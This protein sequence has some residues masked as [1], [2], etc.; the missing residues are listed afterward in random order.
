L[1]ILAVTAASF[2]ESYRGLFIWASDHGLRGTWAAYWPL[3]LDAFI[4]VGEL[5]LF[6]GLADRWHRRDRISAWFVTGVG[7][8][9]SVAANVGHVT[10]HDFATRLTAA[11]PP[12]A[13]A[14][15]LAVGFGVLKRVVA[16]T[17]T[18]RDRASE[19]ASPAD[20]EPRSAGHRKATRTASEQRRLKATRAATKAAAAGEPISA[21]RLAEAHGISRDTAGQILAT[22]K[23]QSEGHLSASMN[24]H[25]PV[26]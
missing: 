18:G 17:D 25:G 11:V 8:A 4:A 3:Q 10:D 21:R 23:A 14:A 26:T 12:L 5:A 19:P 22:V 6:V 16:V 2:A 13:A 24:G 7:L 9:A 20:T 1:V 15:S